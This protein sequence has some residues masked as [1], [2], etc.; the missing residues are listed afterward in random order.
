MNFFQLLVLVLS[1]PSSPSGPI[2]ADE[3]KDFLDLGI[4]IMAMGV[5]L[6]D[7]KM[8]SAIATDK[9]YVIPMERFSEFSSVGA[10]KIG[11]ALLPKVGMFMAGNYF[12]EDMVWN[13]IFRCSNGRNSTRILLI[14]LLSSIMMIMSRSFMLKRGTFILLKERAGV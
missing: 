8:L 11:D 9:R 5:G 4:N 6:K 10:A 12:Q 3:V 2:I 1:N 7:D 13:N 14:S